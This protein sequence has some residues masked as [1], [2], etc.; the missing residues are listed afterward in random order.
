M[1]PLQLPSAGFAL[2]TAGSFVWGNNKM[3]IK[4]CEIGGM[5]ALGGCRLMMQ[6]NNQ[7]I[8]TS[9]R[10]FYDDRAEAR[11]GRS[12]WGGAMALF[13]PSNE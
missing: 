11:L 1:G 5:L 4:N 12:I 13:V 10:S 2:A 3:Q 8:V 6:Y 9:V 7:P